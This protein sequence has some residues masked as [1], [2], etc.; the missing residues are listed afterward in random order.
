[1]SKLR[2]GL[3]STCFSF[4]DSMPASKD[5]IICLA[6]GQIDKAVA[7]F[8]LTNEYA[9]DSVGILYLPESV[10][11]GADPE[12]TDPELADREV[13]VGH[14]L[15][16]LLLGGMPGSKTDCVAGSRSSDISEI[17]DNSRSMTSA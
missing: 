14:G 4:N 6:D 16:S 10:A 7:G 1:M 15:G 11:L 5:R 8:L 3:E 13:G 9:L 17:S 2:T 12:P